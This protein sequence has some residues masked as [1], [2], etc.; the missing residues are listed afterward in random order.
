M[1]KPDPNKPNL[2]VFS[3]TLIELA[4]D[5]KDL[6]VVTSD[7]RGSAR[8][9]PFTEKFHD[10]V[11]EVGI[12]EQNLVGVSAGLASTGKHVFAVSPACFLTARALEQIK[13]D[14]CYSDNPVKIEVTRPGSIKL[15]GEEFKVEPGETEVPLHT[16]VFMIGRRMAKINP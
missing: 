13:N 15:K 1:I 6:Y 16:A 11:V 10:Q 8:L 9:L 5:D 3:E 14:V 12:A 7:S 2:E 4:E